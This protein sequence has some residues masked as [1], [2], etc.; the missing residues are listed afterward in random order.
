MSYCLCSG[1]HQVSG[2]QC[3]LLHAVAEDLFHLFLGHS[4]LFQTYFSQFWL[5]K[6]LFLSVVFPKNQHQPTK[7]LDELTFGIL[8]EPY[9]TNHAPAGSAGLVEKSLSTSQELITSGENAPWTKCRCLE[10][11][12]CRGGGVG[13]EVFCLRLLFLE[14]SKVS[15]AIS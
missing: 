6:I 3:L 1:D 14:V 11:F 4:V 12:F 7:D 15:L 10:Q 9:R 8:T 13:G 5:P 2:V